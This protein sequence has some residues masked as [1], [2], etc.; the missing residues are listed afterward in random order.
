MELQELMANEEQC[1]VRLLTPDDVAEMLGISRSSVYQLVREG[2]LAYVRVM[3]NRIRF[4]PEII[5]YF[6]EMHT[7]CL[8]RHLH[9]S[10]HH[11]A[12]QSWLS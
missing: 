6:I 9:A 8:P 7:F 12:G 10:E 1:P 3:S 2:Q 5:Q 4:T 11:V